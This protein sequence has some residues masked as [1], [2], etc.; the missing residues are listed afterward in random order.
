MKV[1]VTHSGTRHT[2]MSDQSLTPASQL[3]VESQPSSR[4]ALVDA[5]ETADVW[6]VVGFFIR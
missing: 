6:R 5:G 3:D 1:S 4:L 2:E